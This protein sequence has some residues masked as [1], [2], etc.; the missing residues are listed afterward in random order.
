M[1]VVFLH[2]LGL[3]LLFL[4]VAGTTLLYQRL[5]TLMTKR[6]Y[7]A[8][9]SSLDLRNEFLAN[10]IEATLISYRILYSPAKLIY[11]QNRYQGYQRYYG[12][13]PCKYI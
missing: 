4:V 11:P 10:H 8:A 6:N 9:F 5:K 2:G 7:I 13:E 1:P 3:Y 12:A